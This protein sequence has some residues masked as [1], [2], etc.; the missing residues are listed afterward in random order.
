MLPLDP[1]LSDDRPTSTLALALRGATV[2]V[3]VAWGEDPSARPLLALHGFRGDHHGLRRL[4]NALP[5]HT[6]IAPDLPGFGASSAFPEP[7]VHDADAYAALVVDLA[8]ELGFPRDG[9]LV[10]HSYGSVVATRVA[11]V[12]PR[13]FA[14]LVLLNP[15]SE[16]AF[17]SDQAVMTKLAQL[18]YAAGARLPRRLG[19]AILR[20]RLVVDATTAAMRTSPDAATRDYVRDQ[21]RAYFAAFG[22]PELLL[23]SYRSSIA[24]T[25]LD[26]AGDATLPTL[27]VA[28]ESDPLGSA[29]SQERLR[30]AFADARLAVIPRVGHLIHYETP[31]TAAAL[32]ESF[33]AELDAGRA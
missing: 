7:A 2:R 32:I 17:E 13:R 26:A 23:Q 8:D 6:V 16:P 25:A 11:A 33:L 24:H 5:G 15:I 1:P 29:S 20:S 9:V 27:L 18:Y 14:G 4:V 3:W 12:D 30:A 19:E 28:G 10:G 22:D 31:A 21:H